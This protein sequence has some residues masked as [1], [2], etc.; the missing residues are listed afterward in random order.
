VGGSASGEGF[1]GG[2]SL[3]EAA[4]VDALEGLLAGHPHLMM[5][6]NTIEVLQLLDMPGMADAH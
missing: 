5:E 4:D 1:I 2:Y 6:G 3:M